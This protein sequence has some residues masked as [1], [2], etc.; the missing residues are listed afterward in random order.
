MRVLPSDGES[1]VDLQALASFHAP[2][3]E[4]TLA[5]VITIEGIAEV[6]F[7]RFRLKWVLLMLNGEHFRGVMHGAVTIVVVADSAIE[8]MIAQNA[9]EGLP[10][11]GECRLGDSR[12]PHARR[13][14][15][16]ASAYEIPI[17]L[18]YAG[19]AGLNGTQLGVITNL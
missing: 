2:P 7:I 6:T 16:C 18:D 10:P 1:F 14:D 17:H 11:R 12:N 4:D 8:L 3:A 9:I 19:I 5:G 13:N 15:G